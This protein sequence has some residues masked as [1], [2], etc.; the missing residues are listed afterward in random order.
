[1]IERGV[2]KAPVSKQP[3]DNGGSRLRKF[4]GLPDEC[5]LIVGPR[6]TPVVETPAQNT[7]HSVAISTSV[8]FQQLATNE[9]QNFTDNVGSDVTVGLADLV[10]TFPASQKR[11]EKSADRTHAWTRDILAA[12]EGHLSR[13]PL[14]ASIPPM[15]AHQQSFY[16]SDL[17][18]D[19]RSQ[20]SGV[21]TYAEDTAM[22]IPPELETFPRICMID[23]KSPHEI[24]RT[25]ALG[26]DLVTVPFVNSTTENGIAFDFSFEAPHQGQDN[27]MGF[28]LWNNSHA[29]ATTPLVEGCQCYAC[30]KHHRAFLHHLLNAKE[31]LAWTLLQVH[32][33]HVVSTMFVQI[34]DSITDGTFEQKSA[35]FGRAYALDL[36]QPTGEGPRIRGYHMKS[37]GRG[38]PRKNVKAYGRLDDQLMKLQEA[39]SGIATPEEETRAGDLEKQGLGTVQL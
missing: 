17:I 23:P 29:T 18:D 13:R 12:R 9:Y 33:L 38:E 16:L 35:T 6:R 3:V 1:M 15:E 28:D 4:I 14:F 25:V 20:I 34:R 31:M 22:I 37:V 30:T 7:N 2:D 11:L 5:L 10:K 21:T 27:P 8:G 36:P 19:Y 39:D 24:I 26:N 32:N